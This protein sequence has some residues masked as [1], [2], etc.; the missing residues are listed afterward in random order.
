MAYTLNQFNVHNAGLYWHIDH[1]PRTGAARYWLDQYRTF[2]EIEGQEPTAIQLHFIWQVYGGPEE[3][4]WWYTEGT[5]LD[6]DATNCVYG[7]KHCIR[8]CLE[9]TE[10]YGLDK[11]PSISTSQGFEAI[12]ATLSTKWAE[13]YP[14][15]RPYYC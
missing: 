1:Y 15:E 8:R 6:K 4:G 9:L 3:G 14:K 7:K 2:Q 13:S 10:K 12:D 11:Q 5:P